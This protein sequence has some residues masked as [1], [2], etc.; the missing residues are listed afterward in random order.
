MDN[1]KF[2]IIYQQLFVMSKR[3]NIRDEEEKQVLDLIFEVMNK[4]QEL[5]GD[6]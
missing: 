6:E 2:N 3:L 5:W 1:I 4:M